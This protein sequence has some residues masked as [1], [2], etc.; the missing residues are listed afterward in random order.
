MDGW[1][2]VEKDG[3]GDGKGKGKVK[4]GKEEGKEGKGKVWAW[5]GWER[6]GKGVKRSKFKVT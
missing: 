5:V 6:V 4:E 1:E 2:R 3:R